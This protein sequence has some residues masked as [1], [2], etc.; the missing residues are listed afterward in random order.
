MTTS[1]YSPNTELIKDIWQFI[2]PY[3]IRFFFGSVARIAD[4][5]IWLI[6]AWALAEMITFISQYQPGS[7]NSYAWNL[8]GIIA[9]S[10]IM[11]VILS[12]LARF[13]IYFIA[14]KANIDAKKMTIKHMYSLN[15]DWHEKENTGNK[16]QKAHKGGE[17]LNTIIRT[18]I[19]LFIPSLVQFV[20][21]ILILASLHISF[22]FILIFFFITYFLLSQKFTKKP[23]QQGNIANREWENF[24]GF[25]FESI[26]NISIIKSLSIWKNAFSVLE[27]SS[28]KLLQAICNRIY[29]YQIRNVLL[30]V[31]KEIF[32]IIILVF[33][34][35][36][37]FQ[38]NLEIGSLAMVILYFGKIEKSSEDF[39]QIHY[40]FSAAKVA[41]MR[42]KEILNTQPTIETSG[43]KTFDPNW[44][45]L[46]MKNINFSYRGKKVL[47]DFSLT[48]KQG[49]KIGIVGI[50][51]TGKSTLFKLLLKLYNDYKGDIFFDNTSLHDIKRSSY[52]KHIA[53][54]PQ[55]TELFNLSLE[56]NISIVQSKKDKKLLEKSLKIAHIHDFAHK[57]PDGL[58]SL[59]GEKG[60]KLSGG[61]K[62]RVGI[63][64]AIYKNPE[65]L[66]LDEA[67]SHLDIQSEKK[68]QKALHDFFKNIT[69]IVIAHRL[70]TI[71]EMD[72]IIVMDHGK[73]IESGSFDELMK[74]KGKFYTLWETQKF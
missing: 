56:D 58:D 33:T 19:N 46:Q 3:K 7:D 69:A 70:S 72:K 36:N 21:I 68:I 51:G 9:I 52:I 13:S 54:V 50:S 49:E 40:R 57:L 32:R 39:S 17:G 64:R 74:Q 28:K 63:A 42:M 10:A 20:S 66:L 35:Y 47:K 12:S 2:K 61:E 43:H 30:S 38:Q 73:V 23:V 22:A 1:K 14:E 16:I 24:E 31:Y 15:I 29:Y 65:I 6:P 67:T 5:I 55:D 26:N 53:I 27:A 18:Y 11:R 41:L 45:T 59:I 34:I 37:I 8:M 60:I 48:I 25:S 4:S 44:K 71:K 62:Q